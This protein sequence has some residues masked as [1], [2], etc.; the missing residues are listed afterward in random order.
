MIRLDPRQSLNFL[1]Q[2]L[3]ERG[4][5][6]VSK[7][8]MLPFGDVDA[9][10]EMLICFANH[11][12]VLHGDPELLALLIAVHHSTVSQHAHHCVLMTY[13][14]FSSKCAAV[15]FLIFGKKFDCLLR[16]RYSNIITVYIVRLIFVFVLTE[17][18]RHTSAQ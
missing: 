8:N 5:F 2:M 13:M 7:L 18:F 9:L 4:P 16:K 11:S 6:P 14:E 3:S 15:F 17:T 12:R 10:V 1:T